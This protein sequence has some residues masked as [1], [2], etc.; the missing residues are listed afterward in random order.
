M[1]VKSEQKRINYKLS[2]DGKR[3][4]KRGQKQK[5]NKTDVKKK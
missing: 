5:V 1:C 3:K 2:F 4:S